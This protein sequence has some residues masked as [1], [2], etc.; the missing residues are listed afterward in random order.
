MEEQ[1]KMEQRIGELT[2]T[3]AAASVVIQQLSENKRL[4]I[5]FNNFCLQIFLEKEVKNETNF[6]AHS[7]SPVNQFS[8]NNVFEPATIPMVFGAEGQK[9]MCEF[10]LKNVK[11][12]LDSVS[13]EEYNNQKKCE[14]NLIEEDKFSE[15]IDDA[16]AI[17]ESIESSGSDNTRFSDEFNSD[18]ED[19]EEE[20]FYKTQVY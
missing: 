18:S 5:Y 6:K 2:K 13:T 15:K 3:I 10:Y 14:D 7:I 11:K 1:H 12:E 16:E 8:S 17:D 4:K 19:S 9:I 20:M